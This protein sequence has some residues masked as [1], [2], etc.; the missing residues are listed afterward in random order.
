M[1][2]GIDI[3]GTNLKVG[4][5][6][7][8]FNAVQQFSQSTNAAKGVDYVLNTVKRII[9]ITLNKFKDI[10]AVGIG[11]PGIVTDEGVVRISPNLPE[12][13]DVQFGRFFANTFSI[14]VVVDNDA[15]VAALAELEF[16]SAK[17]VKN[18]IF[19]TMGTGVGG[20]IIIDR[21]IYKG[22]NFGAGEIGFMILDP[23]AQKM[24]KTPYR[25]GILE[26]YLGKNQI[27]LYAKKFITKKPKSIMR[28][29]EKTDPYFI[30]DAANK[31]DDAALEIF[32]ELGSYFGITLASVFNLLDMRLAVVGGG[33]SAAHESFYIS[34]I[35]TLRE[36]C[37]PTIAQ[38]V[39]IKRAKF[40]KDSGVIGAALLARNNV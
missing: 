38:H 18:F 33:L 24:L 12:F 4:V 6:D 15:N 37:L 3:G 25:T 28:N 14:P 36:R 22:E 39:E 19:V 34:A 2:M 13:I 40:T 20:A 5:F 27:T 32:T 35:S 30:S 11:I 16:G 31:G 23:F 26:E 21:K 9:S 29:F 17:G 1:Y 10:E 7:E 8:K